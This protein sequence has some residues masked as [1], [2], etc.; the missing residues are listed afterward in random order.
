MH[1]SAHLN[2]SLPPHRKAYVLIQF[3]LE[4]RTSIEVVHFCY[5]R[6]KTPAASFH[7]VSIKMERSLGNLPDRIKTEDFGAENGRGEKR[8]RK[9]RSSNFTHFGE[10]EKEREGKR[11]KTEGR[12]EGAVDRKT[13]IFSPFL[14]LLTREPK[15]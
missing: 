7:V 5:S 12:R 14:C 8:R 10:E 1:N 2:Y 9:R 6:K 3:I 11:E 15:K 4:Q 13:H